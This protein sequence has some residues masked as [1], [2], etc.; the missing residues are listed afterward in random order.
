MTASPCV[1]YDSLTEL[2]PQLVIVEGH[3][4][5]RKRRPA[6]GS[7]HAYNRRIDDDCGGAAG[8]LSA[9]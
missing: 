3:G 9:G 5:G 4:P 6:T 1:N 7:T 8:L 2:S